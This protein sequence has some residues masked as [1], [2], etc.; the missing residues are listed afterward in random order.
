[1]SVPLLDLNAQY[2]PIESAVKA[3]VDS[4]F[5]T[6]Q[7][8]MGPQINEL[9]SKIAD[10]CDC[11]HAI[12]VS[13]G[14]D[15][16]LL[17]LMA[18]DIGP[19]DEVITTPFTF[20]ATAGSIARVGATPVFVDIDNTFNLDV[21]QLESK[22]TANTKAIMPVHLFGQPV[23]MESVN[24]IAGKYNLHVIEDAAQA[25]G[26][27]F[28]NQKVG[29]LGTVGCFSFFPSKNLGT[30]GDGGIVTTNDDELADKMR[31]LRT[32]GE[33][34]K[35]Y[36]H[37]IGGNFRLDTIHAAV[38][39]QK[40]PLLDN[41]H[42]SRIKNAQYY[43]NHLQKLPITLPKIGPNKKMIFNQFSILCDQRDALLAHL[44]A[45]HIGAAIYYPVPLHLQECFKPLQYKIGD[46]PIAEKTAQSILSIPIYS[47]L[48][49]HQ[50]QTV[51]ETITSFFS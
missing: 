1:M 50:K 36:H 16:L 41:Q 17:A 29:S 19:G 9:E 30:C 35:Y 24:G 20:F 45:H 32:H 48:T 46:F 7:F 4:V 14:T 37:L 28:N 2:A 6:K 33:S 12:G 11:A 13:S 18:L 5:T 27:T 22:I 25:I 8:I 42:D 49:D 44:H 26:S 10:Y 39:L 40:L 38:L 34:P 3:A 15:A 31:L 21:T 51:C 47:E 23:D 43:Y